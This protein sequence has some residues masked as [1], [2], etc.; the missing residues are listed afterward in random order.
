[1][2]GVR[3][4]IVLREPV[5]RL[6][7]F[8]RFQQS[9]LLLPSDLTF[10]QYVDACDAYDEEA[11]LRDQ[12]L[13]PWFGILGGNYDRWL[14]AW[15]ET[16][17]PRLRIMFADDLGADPGG[18]MVGLAAWLGLDPGPWSTG[19]MTRENATTGFRNRRLQ[20]A[21]LVGQRVTRVVLAPEPGHQ[22]NAPRAVPALST[23]AAPPTVLPTSC[24]VELEARFRGPL[25]RTAA[26]LRSAGI[27]DLPP[28][29]AR[30][31]PAPRARGRVR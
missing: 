31:S 22:A 15:I 4:V 13:N 20:Q 24:A 11:L 30:G 3:V 1:M 7:S 2:P 29:L 25:E 12:S 10:A 21:A 5:A 6:V 17:G 16:F 9:M 18:A 26:Q 27:T 23:P 28:W 8:Y 19:S 14:P